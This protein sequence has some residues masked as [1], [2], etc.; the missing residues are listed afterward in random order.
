MADEGIIVP[1]GGKAIPPNQIHVDGGVTREGG[2]EVG[3]S[4]ARSTDKT[5]FGVE[6]GI[7]QKKGWR[8]GGFFNFFFGK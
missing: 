5:S 2:A 4:I 7:S 1:G 6:A 8:A 3:G